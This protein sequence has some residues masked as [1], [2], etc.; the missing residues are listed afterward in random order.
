MFFHKS[1]KAMSNIIVMLILIA[2]VLVA[3]GGV[4]VVIKNIMSEE[5]DA[6]TEA[7]LLIYSRINLDIKQ[8][9]ANT[10][11]N[12]LT[13]K[14][15]RNS[16]KG[17]LIGI[18]FIVSNETFSKAVKRDTNLDEFEEQTFVFDLSEFDF[19][20]ESADEVSIAPIVPFRGGESI[21]DIEDTAIIEK[22]S[23]EEPPSCS[24]NSD[25]GTDSWV[26][27][28]EYCNED[29]VWQNWIEYLCD[30]EECSENVSGKFKE[31]CSAQ[32]DVC[33]AGECFN[34]LEC[35]EHS[36][37]DVGEMCE[38][39]ECVPEYLI[40]SGTIY[41]IWPIGGGEYFDSPD[42]AKSDVNYIN[43]FV[44]FSGAESQ[45]LKIVEYI[46][47]DSPD[48]NSYIR[49]NSTSSIQA[50]DNYEIWQTLWGCYN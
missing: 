32:G 43:Y 50:G 5:T 27:G 11:S 40:N 42:L 19:D 17:D 23:F 25:C 48:H 38:N 6:I 7:Q 26:S 30:N 28:T 22:V 49:L 33:F 39:N 15:R 37:C 4:W 45:C 24:E 20:T 9:Q 10:E 13:V 46:Y 2:L 16:G 12:K 14:V 35:F 1:K 3:I 21:K 31:N 8:A 47:P 34:P 29:N 44:K 36:D 18:N 41:S